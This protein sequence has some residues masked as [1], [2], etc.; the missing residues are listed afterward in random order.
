MKKKLK[1]S[2]VI[3]LIS[4]AFCQSLFQSGF[5]STKYYP[6][7]FISD[8][9]SEKIVKEKITINLFVP[10]SQQH[11]Q[12]WNQMRLFQEL[13][14]ETNIAVNFM[15]GDVQSYETQRSNAWTSRNKP[16]A[17]FLWNKISEQIT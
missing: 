1:L 7:N 11:L 12:D 5:N 15:Y 13:E 6:D 14:K 17:F 8:T 2:C 10:R 4:I 9:S 3:L 16:D